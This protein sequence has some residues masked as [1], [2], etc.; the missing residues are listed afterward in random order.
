[1][2]AAAQFTNP[3]NISATITITATLDRWKEL[4]DDLKEVP[5]H[6]VGGELRSAITDLQIKL[7]GQINYQ[8]PASSGES[9]NDD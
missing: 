6:S 1:M 3:G 4:S 2:K 7:C 9:G 8:P 5:F